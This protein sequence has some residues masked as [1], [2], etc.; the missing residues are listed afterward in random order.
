M[1]DWFVSEGAIEIDVENFLSH[2]IPN[3]AWVGLLEEAHVA[4]VRGNI[5][6]IMVEAVLTD[7][8]EPEL[9]LGAVA[10]VFDPNV[11]SEHG[12]TRM[13][14]FEDLGAA[15]GAPLT[16]LTSQQVVTD[17]LSRFDSL[18]VADMGVPADGLGTDKAAYAAALKAFAEGGGQLVL[19]DL[20][21]K[22][23][24]D[25]GVVATDALAYAETNAGHVDFGELGHRW[26]EGLF[27][28]PSQ[29]YYEVPLGFPA[30][31]RAPHHGVVQAAWES[32]GG[33]TVGTVTSDGITAAVLGEV[34]IGS[35]SIAIFGAILPTAEDSTHHPHGL[36][37][38]A[39][40]I[41]GGHVLHRMLGFT[42]G[43]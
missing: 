4:A 38:Y 17:D 28:T 25:L 11:V 24:D 12:S 3:N 34:P 6:A 2:T 15:A 29:T 30:T 26:E 23:L 43:G 35:G 32:A 31:D 21:V 18:V 33:T 5:E 9:D 40:T 16:P 8:V 22:L 10:Y 41:A 39:V 37:D 20:A 13:R 42:R 7:L 27:G 1:G 14:Y 36:A 19:T